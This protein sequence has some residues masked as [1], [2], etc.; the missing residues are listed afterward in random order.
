MYSEETYCA[1]PNCGAWV[2]HVTWKD[3]FAK[4]NESEKVSYDIEVLRTEQMRTVHNVSEIIF[5]NSNG[6]IQYV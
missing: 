1:I 4:N 3:T 6:N 2:L 5:D